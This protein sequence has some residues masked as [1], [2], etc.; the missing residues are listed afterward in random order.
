MSE[1]RP[2]GIVIVML[3]MFQAVTSDVRATYLCVV[4]ALSYSERLWQ[5]SSKGPYC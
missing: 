4:L 5:Q 2:R 1:L 3:N